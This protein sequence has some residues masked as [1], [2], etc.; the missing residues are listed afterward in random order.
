MLVRTPASDRSAAVVTGCFL[1][2][3]FNLHP[4]AGLRLAAPRLLKLSCAD[5]LARHAQEGPEGALA[6]PWSSRG[7]RR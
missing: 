5:S 6:G 7:E 1:F 3:P 2:P 4:L